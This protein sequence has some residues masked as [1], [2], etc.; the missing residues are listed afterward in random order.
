MQKHELQQ[1]IHRAAQ[2][3]DRFRRGAT[4]LVVAEAEILSLGF[5]SVRHGPS[6]LEAQDELTWHTLTL[7]KEHG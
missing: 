5:Q 4:P 1:R 2:A 7:E 3:A 6:G